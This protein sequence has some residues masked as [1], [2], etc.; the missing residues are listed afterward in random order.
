MGDSGTGASSWGRNSATIPANAA[1]LA[2][3]AVGHSM[4]RI[5]SDL[6][7]P[8]N[9]QLRRNSWIGGLG[10]EGTRRHPAWECSKELARNT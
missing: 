8:K 4:D 10:I 1:E 2:V 9:P 7:A 6:A 5:M 3:V